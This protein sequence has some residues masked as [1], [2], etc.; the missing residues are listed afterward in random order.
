[1][2]LIFR[3]SLKSSIGFYIGVA[4]GAVNTLFIS[5]RFL[6]P[7]QLAIS[8][9][10]MENSMIFSAFAYLGVTNIGD[11]FF[12]FFK[13]EENKHNGFL[14]FLFLFP[15]VGFSLFSITYFSFE[16]NFKNYFIEKSPSIVPYISLSLPMTFC[17]IYISILDTYSRLNGR[18][19]IPTFIR[20]VFFRFLNIL[21][22]ILFGIGWI[23]F[24]VFLFLNVGALALMFIAFLVYIKILGKLYF[25][26]NSNIWTKQLVWNI[27][28]F[29]LLVV[30]GGVGANLILFL[31]R[32]II[33]SKI[34]TTAVAIFTISTFIASIIEI[35]SKA[36]RQISSPILSQAIY[37]QDF[38]QTKSLYHKSALNLLLI[39]GALF[40][41]IYI[42]IDSILF[43]LP[44]SDVYKNGKWVVIIIG[45]AK[46]IDMSLGLNNEIITY[47]KYYA[48]NTTLLIVMTFVAIF[49]NLLLIPHFGIIGSA[50]A[51]A[52]V[53]LLSSLFRL[54]F[55]W[56]KMHLFPYQ[57]RD[58]KVFVTLFLV[59]GLGSFL[60][61]MITSK[62]TAFFSI[63]FNTFLVIFVFVFATLK[64]RLSPDIV[65]YYEK[66]ILP[67][68]PVKYKKPN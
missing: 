4:L 5:T 62:L 7:D 13:D 46:W 6:S 32:N 2:G 38:K 63:A 28:K 51:T 26:W 60:P 15:L 8:R 45:L 16:E 58:L 43:L 31:D 52:S 54:A 65:H 30:L 48:L 64:L 59:I 11:K 10:L 55:V 12:V 21:T 57:R 42:N 19:A 14:T 49:A 66:M 67:K 37:Q 68:L 53:I 39:G 20:E 9:I 3:Q 25:S 27:V 17:W 29:G 40:S 61:N 18:I 47:T 24:D 44:K 36:I 1:M 35:P 56:F 22:I 34:G 41:I 33:A 50:M 23:S